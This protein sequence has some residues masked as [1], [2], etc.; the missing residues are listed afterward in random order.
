MEKFKEL[1]GILYE[2]VMVFPH[3]IALTQTI[4]LLKKYNFL[5]TVN[6][7][8]VPLDSEESEDSMFRSRPI[9]TKF[10]K[11]PSLNR[12]YPSRMRDNIAI[13]LFLDNPLLFFT[14]HDFF[15]DSI[16]AFNKTAEIVNDIQ[17]DVIW[18][19]LGYICQYFYLEKLRD[20]GNYDIKSFTSNFIIEN[21]NERDLTYFVQKEESF[22]IPIRQVTVDGDQYSYKKSDG[23][24]LLKISIP[25]G[26]SRHI[27]ID[28]ENE[29]DLSMID[30]S[31]NDPQVNRLRKISDFR[32]MTLS[33]SVLGRSFIRV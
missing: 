29:L 23:N 10:E 13:D 24:L 25:A 27:V 19:S 21:T 28:Y 11:F 12:Y 22:S 8:N 20:D 2:K 31:K 3:G 5:A 32:D 30:I 18:E 6:A 9:T 26:E 33:R 1:I 15:E 14:H 16:D 17:P 7:G 4:G